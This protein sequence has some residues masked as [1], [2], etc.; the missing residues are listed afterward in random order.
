MMRISTLRYKVKLHGRKDCSGA[1]IHINQ[2]LCDLFNPKDLKYV[3]IT[4]D[5]GK[6]VIEPYEG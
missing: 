2:V 3:T 4:Y 1:R 5:D 6:L